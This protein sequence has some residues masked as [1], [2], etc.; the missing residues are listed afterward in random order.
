MC[1]RFEDHCRTYHSF[2]IRKWR[3]HGSLRKVD[4]Q[5]FGVLRLWRQLQALYIPAVYTIYGYSDHTFF[6]LSRAPRRLA[7]EIET[8][9]HLLG[10]QKR[11]SRISAMESGMEYYWNGISSLLEWPLTSKPYY[12]S[13]FCARVSSRDLCS[14]SCEWEQPTLSP[15]VNVCLLNW[16]PRKQQSGYIEG[17]YVYSMRKASLV[18]RTIFRPKVT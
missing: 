10:I 4:G 14:A 15:V 13:W 2:A 9:L 3:V 7:R 1:L 16:V 12:T 6:P 18:P 8:R 5:C 11:L 17:Q